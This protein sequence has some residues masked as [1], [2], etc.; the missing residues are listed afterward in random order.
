MPEESLRPLSLDAERV[1]R[2][3]RERSRQL[4]VRDEFIRI[5]S[6]ELSTPL[7]PTKLALARLEK[8]AL[9]ETWSPPPTVRRHSTCCCR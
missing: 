7:T 8:A 4:R 3:E 6:H 9:P 5:A 2:L 1:F